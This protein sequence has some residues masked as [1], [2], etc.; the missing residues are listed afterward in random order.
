MKKQHICKRCL[1]A[2]PRETQVRHFLSVCCLRSRVLGCGSCCLPA[3]LGFQWC[4]RAA[5]RHEIIKGRVFLR[6]QRKPYVIW[7]WSFPQGEI[8]IKRRT[9]K[10]DEREEGEDA[11]HYSNPKWKLGFKVWWLCFLFLFC[12]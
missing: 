7:C 5:W 11:V 9:K 6:F 4:A 3:R 10:D 12:S 2:H 1:F 8:S